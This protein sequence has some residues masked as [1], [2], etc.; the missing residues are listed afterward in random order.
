M[1]IIEKGCDPWKP[2]PAPED[3]LII[4]SESEDEEDPKGNPGNR[5][6]PTSSITVAVEEREEDQTY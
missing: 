5:R 6:N 4:G 3:E 1:R 2:G